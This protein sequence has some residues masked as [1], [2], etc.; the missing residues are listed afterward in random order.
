MIVDRGSDFPPSIQN[1]LEKYGSDMWM[2]RDQPES[3]TTRALNSYRG[4]FR[5]FEYLTPRIR[6]TPRDLDGTKLAQPAMLHFICSPS[7]A[8]VIMSQVDDVPGWDPITIYEPIP[9]RCVPEELPALVKVLP[10]ISI[11]S[12]NA[13]EALSLLSYD[14]SPSKESIEQAASKLLELGVK[15]SVIVRSG[16]MGAY[17]TTR[18][19]GGRWVSAFWDKS[20]HPGKVIDVTGAGNSFLGGLA[21]GLDIT[22]NDVYEATFYATVSASFTIEQEGLPTMTE[23]GWNDDSPSTRLEMLKSRHRI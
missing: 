8:S 5:G 13:E 17:I 2:F 18:D 4:D 23:A 21:A 6:I 10:S 14:L 19:K 16:S 15:D 20:E 3:R 7:R 22:G 11:L 12:P 9:D 1:E